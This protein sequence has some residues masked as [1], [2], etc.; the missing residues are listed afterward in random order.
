LFGIFSFMKKFLL[1]LTIFALPILL[2]LA[3]P[4]FVLYR[5]GENFL[6]PAAIIN[7]NNKHIV[8]YAYSEKNYSYLKW[9]TF[10]YG[11]RKKVIALGSSR[12]LQFRDEMFTSSFYNAGYTVS[13]I[14]DYLNFLK[15]IPKEKYPDYLIIS[16]D[17]W[18]YNEAWDNM[19]GRSAN[20]DKWSTA[21]VKHPNFTTIMKVWK[22]LFAGKY[23]LDH[24]KEK[25]VVKLI[26]LNGVVNKKGLRNDGSMDY[27]DQMD[28]LRKDTT[29]QYKNIYDR[30][31]HGVRRFEY[32][33]EV[34]AKAIAETG[35]I[36]DFCKTNN[37]KVIA[38]LPPFADKVYQK[39]L[40]S[41][42]YQYIPK[43]HPAIQPLFEKYG[44]ELYEFNNVNRCQS[45]DNETIDGFHGGEVTYAKMLVEMLKSGS[46]LNHVTS[47]KKL[48]RDLAK[49]KDNY[50]VYE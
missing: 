36:L 43:I 39:M 17:Q 20:T 24:P 48:E 31:G 44:A 5:T 26:G 46:A 25:D 30:I 8:G 40:S 47:V 6:D 28:L 15:I 35:R 32:S 1:R 38:I 3:V 12:V 14:R 11:E 27:G 23:G 4:V 49:R 29:G 7:D 34:H 42:N 50:K 22:D 37:I 18:M 41:G 33:K 19:K 45:N 2:F 16:L 10:A 9:K 13:G 21:F